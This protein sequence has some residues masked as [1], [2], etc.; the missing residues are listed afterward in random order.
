M[1]MRAAILYK[2]NSWM[3]NEGLKMYCIGYKLDRFWQKTSFLCSVGFLLKTKQNKIR[4][5]QQHW[6]NTSD[7]CTKSFSREIEVFIRIFSTSKQARCVFLIRTQQALI[8]YLLF[9][10][11]SKT[12]KKKCILKC[13]S[14]VIVEETKRILMK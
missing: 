7:C 10:N 8:C 2:V 5:T 9:W 11:N 4:E 1:E 3:I 13:L 14:C 6:K 12:K